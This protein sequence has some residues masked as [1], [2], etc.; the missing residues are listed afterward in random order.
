M[1]TPPG[2]RRTH[3]MHC[4]EEL[5]RFEQKEDLDETRRRYLSWLD[6]KCVKCGRTPRELGQR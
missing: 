2:K 5:P 3:C 4:G 6:Q 1:T